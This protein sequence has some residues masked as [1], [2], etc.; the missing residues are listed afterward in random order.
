MAL[1]KDILSSQLLAAF[2]DRGFVSEIDG[3]DTKLSDL[4]DVIASVII[5]HLINNMELKLK[6]EVVVDVDFNTGRV[7]KGSNL[8]VEVK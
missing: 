3:Q 6:D 1:D 5:D 4:C 8:T 2:K 7:S